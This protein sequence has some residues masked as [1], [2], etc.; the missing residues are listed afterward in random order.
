M[1]RASEASR[2]VLSGELRAVLV[3]QT[4]PQSSLHLT[5]PMAEPPSHQSHSNSP[6]VL[7]QK[8]IHG[9]TFALLSLG[10]TFPPRLDFS[11][12]C[13]NNFLRQIEFPAPS[14]LP[15][16]S[17]KPIHLRETSPPSLTETKAIQLSTSTKLLGSSFIGAKSTMTHR[18]GTAWVIWEA[19]K[20]FGDWP[21]SH[22]GGSLEDNQSSWVLFWPCTRIPR[23]C[24][25]AHGQSSFRIWG[26][27]QLQ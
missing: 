19:K 27:H 1:C 18:V 4:H 6:I 23:T 5:N 8:P 9:D 14:W 13:A 24:R 26:F 11:Q 3:V 25:W 12:P 20:I 7:S 17:L 21:W 10:P 15:Q 22:R 2:W 16:Q